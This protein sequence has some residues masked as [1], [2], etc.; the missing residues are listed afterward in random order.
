MDH[1]AHIVETVRGPIRPEQLGPAL[2]HEHIFIASPEGVLNHNH[3]WGDPWWD[4]EL[5]VADA[6]TKL[7]EVHDLGIRT[8]VDPTAFGL[9]RNVPR[10]QRVNAQVDLHI[11]VCTGLYAFLEVPAYL[12]YRSAENLA[13]I[14]T[15]E[16]EVGI[17]DTGVKAAFLKCAIESYGVVGDLPLI[18]DAVGLTHVETGAPVM[19]HTNGESQTGRLALEELRTRGVDPTRIVIAHA[20]DSTDLDYLRHLA[21]AGAMLGFDRFNTPFSTD[22]ARVRSIVALIAD[23]YIDRIHLSHD[24]STFNDFMQHNPPFA[25]ATLSYTH[26]HRRVLPKLREAGITDGQ[27]DEMLTANARRFLAG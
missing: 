26:I 19:V 11:V 17:D 20:G 13:S 24:A 12:K 21:G 5:R 23:G 8:L 2:L 6:V 16:I 3:T 22:D 14:F 1:T 18:L 25:S 15:R 9:S 10:I 27:I 4:E 7:H